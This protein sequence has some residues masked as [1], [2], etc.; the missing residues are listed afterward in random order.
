[1][2]DPGLKV[3]PEDAAFLAAVLEGLTVERVRKKVSEWA[4]EKRY[5]PPELTAKP[6]KW[7]N[8]Y[9]PYLTEIM[10]CLSPSH[11]AR[12]VAVEKGAQIGA[13][14]GILENFIG[15]TID[16]D[17]SG[18]IYVSADKELT[19][20]GMELKVDRMLHHS[21][22]KDLLGA[23]DGKSK[24]SGD[25]ATMK[26]FPGGFLLA[27]GARNPG[28]LRS[29]PAKK[30]VLDELDGMPLILGG[31]GQEEGNPITIIE[32]RTDSYEATRKILYLSTPLKLQTSL[33]HPLFLAG[34]QRYFFI[35][36]RH[37]GGM[38]HLEWHGVTEAGLEYGF[39]FDLDDFGNLVEESVGYSCRQCEAIFY[40]HDK[41][42][43]LPRGKWRPTSVP[44][45]KGLVSFHLPSFY[46]PPGMYPWKGT[47]YKWLKAWDVGNDRMRDVAHL[48]TDKGVGFGSIRDRRGSETSAGRHLGDG[49]DVRPARAN[50]R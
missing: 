33:I 10:D 2:I 7:D 39:V 42:W 15:Y 44:N 30:A 21:G 31:V 24:R 35:P 20:M 23:P 36:C 41:S 50:V 43:F 16:H 40:N 48:E 17:P 1:M 12:K 25:T 38:Q 19:K 8:S 4:E 29:T 49:I 27:V 22:L 34:D 47:C 46:S 45:E 13:T 37:C 14:T 3:H 9:T 26:E 18:M 32:K 5:L 11:P 6:G 28:K